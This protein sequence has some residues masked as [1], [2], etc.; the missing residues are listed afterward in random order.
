M[1]T[2]VCLFNRYRIPADIKDAAFCVGARRSQGSE[3]VANLLQLYNTTKT[4]SERAS[5]INA[6]PCADIQT[7][8]T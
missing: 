5:V 3:S 8:V 7:L 2:L 1:R 6:L 4:Y